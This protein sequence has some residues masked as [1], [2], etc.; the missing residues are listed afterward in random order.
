MKYNG[1]LS[2]PQII[3]ILID[4]C[5]ALS[6][7]HKFGIQ[8]RDIKVENILLDSQTK[9]FR[10]CDF[11]SAS[12]AVLDYDDAELSSDRVDNMLDY[13]EKFTTMM[14]RPPEMIDKYMKFKVDT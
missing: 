3:H 6:H 12:T 11:G 10:L 4:V 9:S 13:F 2:E 7:M 1:N 5:K 14:Y 8:H